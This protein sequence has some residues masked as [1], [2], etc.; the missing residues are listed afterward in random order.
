MSK[1]IYKDFLVFLTGYLSSLG[2]VRNP[3]SE[4]TNNL[5]LN[6]GGLI[7][8]SRFVKEENTVLISGGFI[9][10]TTIPEDFSGGNNF[11]LPK[12]LS[13][14]N[15]TLFSELASFIIS[16]SSANFAGRITSNP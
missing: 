14:E 13:K 11:M 2:Y 12:S 9:L 6:S 1:N 3:E 5:P 15:I 10:I 8:L 16:S 4:S 7:A